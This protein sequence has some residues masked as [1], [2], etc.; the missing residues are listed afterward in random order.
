MKKILKILDYTLFK[1]LPTIV[2]IIIIIFLICLPVSILTDFKD[3]D[4]IG[5][6]TNS[7]YVITETYDGKNKYYEVSKNGDKRKTEAFV[8]DKYESYYLKDCLEAYINKDK[9]KVLNKFKEKSC[10]IISNPNGIIKYWELK[11]K[12]LKNIILKISELE[13]EKFSTKIYK[14]NDNYYVIV[15]NNVNLWNPFNLYYYDKEENSLKLIYKFDGEI[16]I[17]IKE[18]GPFSPTILEESK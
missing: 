15:N 7:I 1:L 11:D 14:I 2:I 8:S 10:Q 4:D 12:T 18:K 17:G 3:Y 16:I 13:H 6:Y 9:N 5:D